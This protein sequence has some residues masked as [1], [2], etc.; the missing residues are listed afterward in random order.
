MCLSAANILYFA[1]M[2]FKKLDFYS[3]LFSKVFNLIFP[4]Y[5]SDDLQG[6]NGKFLRSVHSSNSSSDSFYDIFNI[7]CFFYHYATHWFLLSCMSVLLYP[8]FGYEL[9]PYSLISTLFPS[10][11]SI[12]IA[13]FFFFLLGF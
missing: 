2:F 12:P 8:I 4:C 7:M 9:P 10:V 11:P 5:L 6:K 3:C 1:F 13:S